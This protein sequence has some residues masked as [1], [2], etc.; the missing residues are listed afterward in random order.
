LKCFFEKCIKEAEKDGLCEIHYWH[1]IWLDNSKI[2]NLGIAV[3]AKMIV[4]EWIRSEIPAFHNE[5]YYSFVSLYSK[6]KVDKYDRLL[7]EIA[8]RGAAKTTISKIILLYCCCFS[9]EKLIIYCSET[10]SFAVQDVSEVKRELGNNEFIK[11]YFGKINSKKVMGQDG[12]W[13]QDAFMTM[14][15]PYVN[16]KRGTYVLAR[17]VGQQVRSALRN[18]YRPTLAIVNDM[19]SK[20]TVKT[21]YTRAEMAKWFFQDMFNAV[22]DIDGKVF[23]NGTILHQDTV[24]VTLEQND[25]WKVLKYPVMDIEDF[26]RLLDEKNGLCEK[27]ENKILIKDEEGIRKFQDTCHLYWPERLNLLYILK[28]YKEAYESNQSAG[29]F[30][31]Y[32]HIVVPMDEK[33]FKNIQRVKMNFIRA[34]NKTWLK[35]N[36][37]KDTEV[38]YEV[39][40]FIGL[41]AASGTTQGSKF[42]VV[43]YLA[44]NQF[45][46]IFVLGYSRGKYGMRDE[47]KPGYRKP[48]D[49]DVVE[50]DRSNL[51]RIGMVDEEIRL[52]KQYRIVA[53]CI[54]TVQQQQSIFD[55]INRIMRVNNAFHRLHSVKPTQEKIERDANTLM[56]FFQSGSIY[57][58]YGL[59]ALEQEIEQFPRAATIDII[60][61]LQMAVSIATPSDGADFT[62]VYKRKEENE[63]ETNFYVL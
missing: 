37:D 51:I 28:K 34:D 61:A 24:P 11:H 47:L 14:P 63:Y 62:E 41:D 52:V 44:M 3:F 60:D 2:D 21:E 32:F 54:E 59:E 13:S 58:N 5:V 49:S 30:Q 17:G 39:N 7:A 16:A 42:S 4:P 1:R 46:Q 20:D 15:S 23:F 9:L 18:S 27:T 10:N 57:F 19:Y 26:Y 50:A 36:F 29:F 25:S 8:F 33:S 53:S 48:G 6:D 40:M 45:R 22:D 12:K 55:E 56:P 35:V 43:L 31:E 38:I